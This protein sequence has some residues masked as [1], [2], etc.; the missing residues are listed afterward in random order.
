VPRSHLILLGCFAGAHQ[1]PQGLGTLIRNP[2]RRQISRSIATCQLLS[3]A[4]IRLDSITRLNRYQRWRYNLALDTQFCQLP[5]H[6]ITGRSCLITGS[7]LLCRARF[8][9]QLAYRF[10]AVRN[11]S[12]ASH[13]TIWLGDRHGN[14]FGMDIQ[15]Q[16]S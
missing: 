7:Q 13:L 1:I 5:V 10:G 9:D 16:K 12:Q 8:P 14:R 6:D 2:H 15:T 4:S 3:I 11:R